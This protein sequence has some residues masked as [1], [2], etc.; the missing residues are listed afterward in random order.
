M[1]VS[2]RA[3]Q[4][5]G[6]TNGRANLI[7][8]HRPQHPARPYHYQENLCNDIWASTFLPKDLHMQAKIN[9]ERMVITLQNSVFIASARTT[10]LR[11]CD[12]GTKVT[13][14]KHSSTNG[15]LGPQG[16]LDVGNRTSALVPRLHR[17]FGSDSA[18]H[19]LHRSWTCLQCL[20]R[21]PH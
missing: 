6:S 1:P 8:H 3:G 2:N 5:K 11:G 9:E 7:E 4:A 17:P 15:S 16:C 14:E 19:T 13:T 21:L 18:F 10:V 12:V 20:M